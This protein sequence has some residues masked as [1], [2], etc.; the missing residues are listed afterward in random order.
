MLTKKEVF[1]VFVLCLLFFGASFGLAK[2]KQVF[3]EKVF[4][5]FTFHASESMFLADC[6][7]NGFQPKSGEVVLCKS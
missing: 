7:L 5:P 1:F 2:A 4:V 3:H 6:D